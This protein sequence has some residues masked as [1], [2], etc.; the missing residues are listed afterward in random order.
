MIRV[1]FTGGRQIFEEICEHCKE[2]I[3][4]LH[5]S[6][7]TFAK[8]RSDGIT[9][10]IR[11]KDNRLQTLDDPK[12]KI[13]RTSASFISKG[14]LDVEEA[15]TASRS[16]GFK[17]GARPE[18]M[19]SQSID[20]VTGITAS[21]CYKTTNNNFL[22][23]YSGSFH[24]GS[25]VDTNSSG[26]KVGVDRRGN[27]IRMK[28][29]KNIDILTGIPESDANIKYK[30]PLDTAWFR[31]ASSSDQA[32]YIKGAQACAAYVKRYGKSV[33]DMTIVARYSDAKSFIT[34]VQL[35]KGCKI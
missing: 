24:T 12:T 27:V 34:D 1:R 13:M 7:V 31:K 32:R 16:R 9:F 29:I 25:E 11:D 18:A 26:S 15:V 20:T 8:E 23:K 14:L 6:D 2:K 28:A 33:E 5:I 4:D 30:G 35:N 17:Y 22:L 21:Y 3:I 19:C 10:K